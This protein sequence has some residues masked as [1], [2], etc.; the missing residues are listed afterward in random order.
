[1]HPLPTH[2]FIHSSGGKYR[3]KLVIMTYRYLFSVDPSLTC[4][5]WALFSIK[6]ARLHAVGK[7]PSLS[8]KINLAERLSDLQNKIRVIYTELN[9][10]SEDVVVCESPTTMR[11]PKAAIK[12]EQVRSIFET[13]A[14]SLGIYVPGRINP[15]S[16]QSE[17]LGIRGKQI[18]RTFVKEIAVE[19]VHSLYKDHLMELGFASDKANLKKHQDIVDAILLGNLAVSRINGAGRS[20][21]VLTEVF[22]HS[23]PSRTGKLL[24]R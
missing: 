6:N 19:V 9:L 12:V 10:N 2:H 17:L 7:I 1:M 22:T 14:R 13:L 8:T 3:L 18:K 20:G 15:R 5:G 11:D 23:Q 24:R 21:A 4:S 16:V